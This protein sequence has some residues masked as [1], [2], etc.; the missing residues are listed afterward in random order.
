V[1]VD[2]KFQQRVLHRLG[3]LDELLAEGQLDALIQS[4][5]RFVVCD[6]DRSVK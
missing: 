6:P 4:L 5:R 1:R 3:L 2:G